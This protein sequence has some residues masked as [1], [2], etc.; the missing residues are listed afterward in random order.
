MEEKFKFINLLNTS[1][2][3]K[4][5]IFVGGNSSGNFSV[6]SVGKVFKF[7]ESVT[8]QSCIYDS[9]K[10][11]TYQISAVHVHP[12]EYVTSWVLNKSLYK[13]IYNHLLLRDN[14]HSKFVGEYNE[15]GLVQFKG[16]E[17]ITDL[18]D[19][20]FGYETTLNN[21]IGINEP[22]LAETINRCIGEVY[23]IQQG[24]VKMCGERIAN[25]YPYAT[26]VVRL[27]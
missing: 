5:Y 3:S 17:Y 23:T 25:K 15:A 4:D 26:Q 1:D 19:N 13:L 21:F 10:T 12:D 16:I 20:L 14:F 9:Y 11:R 22:I 18:D 2:R 6:S 27:Q 24:L 7:E 8:Y